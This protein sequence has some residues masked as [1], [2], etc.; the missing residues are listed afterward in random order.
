VW[1]LLHARAKNGSRSQVHAVNRRVM[2]GP[3]ETD[4]VP[5]GIIEIG[6]VNAASERGTSKVPRSDTG[7]N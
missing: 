4:R 2:E 5:S 3:L 1:V 6:A 7:G